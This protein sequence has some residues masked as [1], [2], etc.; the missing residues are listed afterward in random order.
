MTSSAFLACDIQERVNKLQVWYATMSP[1]TLPRI[2]DFYTEQA[3]FKDPFNEV[4]ERSKI[5]RIF[6]HMFETTE[7]P[8]FIFDDCIIS[9]DQAFLSWRFVFGLRGKQY[10]VMGASH[11]RFASDGKVCMHRDYWDPAEEL[12]E[13]LPILGAFIGWLRKKFVAA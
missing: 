5:K 6:E 10:K 8:S 13:K 4:N 3:Y 12:W 7:N 1:Q 9:G 2:D 11:L